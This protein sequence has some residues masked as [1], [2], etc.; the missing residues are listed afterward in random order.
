MM[1]KTFFGAAP[2]PLA[3]TASATTTWAAEADQATPPASNGSGFGDIVVTA[4]KRSENVQKVPIAVT[5]F[6]GDQLK[7]LG[8]TDT[9][10]ITQHVPGL[11]LNAWS[12]NITIFN[13]RG[14][15]Q[16]NFADYLESPVAV[17]VDDA[18]LGS[19]NGVSGQLFDIQRVEVLRG[20][21][22]TL[23]GRNATGGLIQY[24]SEDAS[25][26]RFNGYLTAGYERFNH[27]SVEGAIGAALSMA[28]ASAW[29]AACPRP[30]ATSSRAK[31]ATARRWAAKTA[32]PCVA[33]SR[34]IWDRRASSTCGSSTARTTM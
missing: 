15:S 31:A 28:S 4:N 29:R 13:L 7:A 9:T 14:V 16:N 17:Y 12:P 8:V 19:M 32:G 21:Q 18:Y 24:V 2:Y 34:P 20:P 10:Q 27:R 3:L 33:P 30:T 6:S 26:S 25:K 11:Q 1:G 22:G 5:A 23:F